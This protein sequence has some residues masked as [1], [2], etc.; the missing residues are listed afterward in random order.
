M[1]RDFGLPQF[2]ASPLGQ[3]VEP[4]LLAHVREMRELARKGEAPAK[5]VDAPLAHLVPEGLHQ[6]QNNSHVGRW[7]YE[8]IGMDQFVRNGFEPFYGKTFDKPATFIEI[9]EPMIRRTDPRPGGDEFPIRGKNGF[10]LA[11]GDLDSELKNHA[12]YAVYVHRL[13]EA[14]HLIRAGY[15]IRMG[16]RGVRP[17]LISPE[18]VEIIEPA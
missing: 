3:K 5:A 18:S 8:L 10:Q 9:M 6:R 14:A 11:R 13:S 1:P 2:K 16:R 7:I 15:S 4:I 17:S 12:E